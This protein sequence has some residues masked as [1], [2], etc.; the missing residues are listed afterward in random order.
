MIAYIHPFLKLFKIVALIFILYFNENGKI[1]S[2]GII[3]CK[4]HWIIK[5]DNRTK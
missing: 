5:Q 2:S 3:N 4:M 1:V